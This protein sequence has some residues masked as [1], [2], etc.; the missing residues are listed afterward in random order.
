MP[1]QCLMPW[2]HQTE[3]IYDGCRIYPSLFANTGGGQNRAAVLLRPGDLLRERHRLLDAKPP[4]P[5]GRGGE[6]GISNEGR[7]V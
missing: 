7:S 2:D 4:M 3:R 1:V 6:T 5:T